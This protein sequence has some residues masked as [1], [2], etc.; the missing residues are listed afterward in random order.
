[1]VRSVLLLALPLAACSPAPVKSDTTQI[2]ESNAG[3]TVA[4]LPTGAVAYQV[5]ACKAA[6]AV[7]MGRDPKTM[8]GK[9]VA[10]DLA[11]ISYIRKDDGK[12]WQNRCRADS[13]SKL[14]WAAFDA[15]GDGKQGRWR[16]EESIDF[17]VEGKK[18]TVTVNQF[19]EPQTET[20][21]LADLK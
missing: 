18:L 2:A 3:E 15:F 20:F 16:T 5:E 14:T 12:R 7:I 13:T 4:P 11:H 17:K 6:I 21:E 19:G 1:M 8:S 10:G 9:L